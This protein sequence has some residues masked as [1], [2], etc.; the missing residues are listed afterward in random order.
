MK[1]LITPSQAVALAFTDGEYVSPAAVGESD[2]AAAMHRYV[3]PVIGTPLAEALAEGRYAALTEDFVAPALAMSVRTLIQRALTVRTGQVGVEEGG[4]R[5]PTLARAPPPCA[6]A[7]A[8]GPSRR[9]QGGLSGVPSGGGCN[10][11]MFDRWRLC[12][13]ILTLRHSAW[14]RCSRPSDRSS[15]ARYSS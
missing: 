2:I 15:A 10:E 4:R 5:T 6:A 12:S 8:V 13:D 9:T 11:K 14:R 7:P 3:E 1:T